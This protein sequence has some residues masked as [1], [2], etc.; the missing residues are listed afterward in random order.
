VYL[1]PVYA[2]QLIERVAAEPYLA[3]AP[4]PACDIPVVLRHAYRANARRHARDLTLAILL[5]LLIVLGFAIG[6]AMFLLV[7]VASWVVVLGYELSTRYGAAL[8]GLRSPDTG[9]S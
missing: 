5:G 6:F 1:D 4:S 2:R 3:V 8:S 7:L 9:S